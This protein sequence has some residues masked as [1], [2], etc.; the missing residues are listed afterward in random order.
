MKLD[1]YPTLYSTSSEIKGLTVRP[2]TTKLLEENLGAVFLDISLG[3][4][5]LDLMPKTSS[6]KTKINK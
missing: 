2:G 5:F 3:D 1:H 6:T 4:D